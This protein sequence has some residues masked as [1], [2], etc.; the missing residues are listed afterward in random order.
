MNIEQAQNFKNA[1]VTSIKGDKKAK[2]EAEAQKKEEALEFLKTRKMF[3]ELLDTPERVEKF[4]ECR[5]WLLLHVLVPQIGLS[6]LTDAHFAKGYQYALE[7]FEA[8]VEKWDNYN[9]E[10]NGGAN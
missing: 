9:K 10:Y 4:K 3:K 1:K 8:V 5:E 7:T 6:E 2:A